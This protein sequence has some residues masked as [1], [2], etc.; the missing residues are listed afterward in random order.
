[1]WSLIKPLLQGGELYIAGPFAP[2]TPEILK[3]YIEPVN[4]SQNPSQSLYNKN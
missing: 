3:D 1:V 4:V 2:V